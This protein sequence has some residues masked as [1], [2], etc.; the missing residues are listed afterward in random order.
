[1]CIVGSLIPALSRDSISTVLCHSTPFER[2]NEQ[3]GATVEIESRDRG[4]MREPTVYCISITWHIWR[5]SSI[6]GWILVGFLLYSHYVWI[7]H[8]VKFLGHTSYQVC[9]CWF[10]VSTIGFQKKN[11]S[12]YCQPY[13]AGLGRMSLQVLVDRFARSLL[14]KVWMPQGKVRQQQVRFTWF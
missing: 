1:M 7:Y 12:Y 3:G 5:S 13:G 2:L 14:G 11:C 10:L 4:D 6:V 9:I 8:C